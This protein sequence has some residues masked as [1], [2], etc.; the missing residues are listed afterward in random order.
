[1]LFNSLIGST[2]I[3]ETLLNMACVVNRGRDP[4][5]LAVSNPYLKEKILTLSKIKPSRLTTIW[6]M[7]YR[8]MLDRNNGNCSN[9]RFGVGPGRRPGPPKQHM[10]AV[11]ALVFSGYCIYWYGRTVWVM[12]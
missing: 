5:D 7:A 1:M 2:K 12:V 10:R 9:T 3:E 11:C 6:F 8:E 4:I